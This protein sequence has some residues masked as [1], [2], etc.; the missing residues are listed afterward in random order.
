VEGER[1]RAV[2][3]WLVEEHF[4]GN[5]D[6]TGRMSRSL[7]DA[8]VE[9]SLVVPAAAGALPSQGFV[10]VRLN[11]GQGGSESLDGHRPDAAAVR[12]RLGEYL[13]ACK[14]PAAQVEAALA[15]LDRALALAGGW[16]EERAASIAAG[17][18]HAGMSSGLGVA[19]EMSM[20]LDAPDMNAADDIGMVEMTM[21]DMSDMSAAMDMNS[22]TDTNVTAGPE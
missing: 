15:G 2:S 7:D 19:E 4:D 11:C 20:D 22:T 13:R 5:G 21:D 8:D 3:D 9:Y 17:M 12:D 16:A 6:V 1:R 18:D 10:V 14:A